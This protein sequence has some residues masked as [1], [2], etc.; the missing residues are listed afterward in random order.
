MNMARQPAK[1]PA[2]RR[3]P[4][5][6]QVLQGNVAEAVSTQQSAWAAPP[7]EPIYMVVR[8][9]EISKR[10]YQAAEKDPNVSAR[11]PLGFIITLDEGRMLYVNEDDR[12]YNGMV[13]PLYTDKMFMERQTTGVETTTRIVFKRVGN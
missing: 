5:P 1:K 9:M 3:R 2:S 13:D 6:T 11:R 7:T 10:Q 4:T 12:Y 8:L